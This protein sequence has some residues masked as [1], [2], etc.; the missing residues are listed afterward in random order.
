MKRHSNGRFKSK[1]RIEWEKKVKSQIMAVLVIILVVFYASHGV[2]KAIDSVEPE[3]LEYDQP[4][5][6]RERPAHYVTHIDW[7]Q[8]RIR[9]QVEEDATKY[10]VDADEM[11]NVIMCESQDNG[12]ASTTIQSHWVKNGKRENSWGLAQIH[13]DSHTNVTREQAIDPLFAI[14][15]MAKHFATGDKWMWTCWREMYNLNVKS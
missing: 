3:V 8:S 11:W 12:E 1:A 14:D 15:F 5:E 7:T 10:G 9:K 6:L 2:A 4:R 13:L